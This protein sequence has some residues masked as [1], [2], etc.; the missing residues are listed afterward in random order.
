MPNEMPLTVLL[1]VVDGDRDYA[2][3]FSKAPELKTGSGITISSAEVLG[4]VGLTVT[5]ITILAAA[6]DGIPAGKGVSFRVSGFT[7]DAVY[8]LACR[9]TLSNGRKLVVPGRLVGVAEVEAMA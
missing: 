8:P 2:A 4:A 1:G 3:D 6:F 9:A 5:E 7:D